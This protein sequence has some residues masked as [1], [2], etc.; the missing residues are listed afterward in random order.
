MKK[1]KKTICA[2]SVKKVLNISVFLFITLIVLFGLWM[3]NTHDKGFDNTVYDL[4]KES[5][6]ANGF[7]VIKDQYGKQLNPNPNEENYMD[8]VM[9]ASVMFGEM[10][11]LDIKK[12]VIN[13]M[14][15]PDIDKN[16]E[17]IWHPLYDVVRKTRAHEYDF[18]DAWIY[19]FIFNP[20]IKGVSQTDQLT[21]IA[22]LTAV[23][24]ADVKYW[25]DKTMSC[26]KTKLTAKEMSELNKKWI[27]ATEECMHEYNNK[28]G[29]LAEKIYTK[30]KLLP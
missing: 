17:G 19:W 12:Q 24:R 25:R 4:Y 20:Q 8:G 22:I 28:I 21:D 23:S 27:G 6:F 18:I 15:I 11:L 26:L 16:K 2:Q 13:Q 14:D 5:Q 1:Q 29:E 7:T 3:Y 9:A 30:L 10:D